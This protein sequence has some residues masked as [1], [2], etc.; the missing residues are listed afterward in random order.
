[1][2][3]FVL[4]QQPGNIFTS[5]LSVYLKQNN[6]VFNYSAWTKSFYFVKTCVRATMT[7]C[8]ARKRFV[9]FHLIKFDELRRDISSLQ[10]HNVIMSLMASQIN[11]LTIVN[12]IVYSGVDQRKLQSSTSLAFLRG[13]HWWPVKSLHKGPVTR[14]MFPFDDVIIYWNI[15]GLMV[16][17]IPIQ[18]NFIQGYSLLKPQR[19][20]LLQWWNCRLRA[21]T[22]VSKPESRRR[23]SEVCKNPR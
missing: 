9:I 2:I 15:H 17:L 22:I 12:S 14:K 3:S 5:E 23:L 6:L 16:I 8:V 19:L 4:T 11:S 20:R 1:M 10:W 13:I 21:L 7:Q 18:L